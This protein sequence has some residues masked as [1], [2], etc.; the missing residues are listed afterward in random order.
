[1]VKP[2]FEKEIGLNLDYEIER[3]QRDGSWR[4]N[5]SWRGV[6]PEAWKDAERDWKGVL[7]VRT[8][9]Q[10]QLFDPLG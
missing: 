1:M 8:L 4:P 10:L 6:F 2:S 5:F 7:T 3:Q 9:R